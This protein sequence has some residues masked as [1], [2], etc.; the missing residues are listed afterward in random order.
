MDR[1][2]AERRSMVEEQIA[3]RGLRDPHLLDAF[4]RVPRHLFVPM[5]TRPAAYSDSPL[6]IGFG[7]TISQPY[8][9]ALMTSLLDLGGGER[10]LEIGTGSGYQAAI[11]SALAAEVHSVELVP[12]LAAR[13]ARLLRRMGLDRLHVHVADGGLGWPQAAPYSAILVTAAAP[14]VPKPLLEQLAE[15]G[16]LV[17]P[18]ASHQGYEWL[19]LVR[20][21]GSRYT[22]ERI[23]SVVFVPLRGKYG[24]AAAR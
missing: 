15:G 7:Q 23:A 9:V 22:E 4:D 16:R 20:H 14:S 12:E 8:I 24:G 13:A 1:F 2:S 10:V 3:R 18:I 21:Q 19:T 5:H 11:L 6:A 17:A